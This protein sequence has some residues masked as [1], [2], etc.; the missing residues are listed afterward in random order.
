MI[1]PNTYKIGSKTGNYTLAYQTWTKYLG[2]YLNDEHSREK[3]VFEL[4]KKITK[5]IGIFC[6]LRRFGQKE[7]LMA[8]YNTFIFPR[9]NHVTEACTNGKGDYLNKLIQSQNKI[10]RILQFK[11]YTSDTNDLHRKFKVL[12]MEDTLIIN[13]CIL[14]HNLIYSTNKV[15]FAIQDLFIQHKDECS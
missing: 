4:N 2:I 14:T 11:P 10:L 7:C 15:P 6:K 3:Q 5:N 8:L 13:L 1:I 9:L 12:R